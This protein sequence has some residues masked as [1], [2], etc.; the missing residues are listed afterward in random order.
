MKEAKS[1]GHPVEI[2]ESL[3]GASEDL[4]K[5]K[6]EDRKLIDNFLLFA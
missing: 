2:Q 6:A 5:L 4:E 1:A 3:F